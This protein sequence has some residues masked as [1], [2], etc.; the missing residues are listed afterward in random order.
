MGGADAGQRGEQGQQAQDVRDL[1]REGGHPD[2]RDAEARAE[3]EPHPGE[4]SQDRVLSQPHRGSP[5]QGPPVAPR[6]RGSLPRRAALER[7]ARAPDALVLRPNGVRARL[8]HPGASRGGWACSPGYGGQGARSA[9][10]GNDS[11][12]NP[13]FSHSHRGPGRAAALRRYRGRELVLGAERQHRG[14]ARVRLGR[15]V[16]RRAH[17]RPVP[18]LPAPWLGPARGRDVVPGTAH[19]PHQGGAR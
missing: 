18:D 8:R 2:R 6:E 16:R 5:G 19:H 14:M 10:L 9:A 12:R 3:H 1:H 11:D 15:P 13:V 7:Q 4:P 17:R